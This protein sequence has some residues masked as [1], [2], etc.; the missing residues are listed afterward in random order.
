[1]FVFKSKSLPYKHV[2]VIVRLSAKHL[3]LYFLFAKNIENFAKRQ[4]SNGA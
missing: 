1:M 4:L 3:P 2:L